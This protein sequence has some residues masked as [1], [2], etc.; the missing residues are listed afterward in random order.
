LGRKRGGVLDPSK[1]SVRT[2][3]VRDFE[4]ERERESVR[5]EDI[6]GPVVTGSLSMRTLRRQPSIADL[7]R[8]KGNVGV[9]EGRGVENAGT[10]EVEGVK[11]KESVILRDIE[12]RRE[13]RGW[14][15]GSK[16]STLTIVLIKLTH[17]AWTRPRPDREGKYIHILNDS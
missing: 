6:S 4:K 8:A 2:E 13:R 10:R 17:L 14:E 1:R 7:H 9:G 15:M 11:R 16:V 12:N 5:K 3:I